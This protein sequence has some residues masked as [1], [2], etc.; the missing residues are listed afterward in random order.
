M[1]ESSKTPVS[2]AKLVVKGLD[3]YNKKERKKP[4]EA[5]IISRVLW[6]GLLSFP[7]PDDDIVENDDDDDDCRATNPHLP[8]LHNNQRRMESV[9]PRYQN[10]STQ[11]DSAHIITMLMF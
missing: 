3:D 2:R 10:I 1:V 7:A 5:A 11:E 4:K 9:D 8:L 6:V